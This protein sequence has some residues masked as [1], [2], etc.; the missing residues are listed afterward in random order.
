MGT[1]ICLC[2][3]RSYTK[4][5][6]H[7]MSIC[8]AE[9]V[10]VVSFE[11]LKS[12]LNQTWFIDIIWEPSYVH[13]KVVPRSKVICGQVVNLHHEQTATAGD[14][15]GPGT[16]KYFFFFFFYKSEGCA[17]WHIKSQG[18]QWQFLCKKG[19]LGDRSQNG[20]YCVWNCTK[21][22]QFRFCCCCYYLFCFFV[23]NFLCDL[24]FFFKIWWFRQ[25]FW[26]K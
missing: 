13:A 23:W 6:G 14:T 10:K 7:L 4:V 8:K 22:G 24:Q 18:N 17:Y 1:F 19:S 9:N 12:D 20:G 25:K 26:L 21:S 2:G 16:A 11:K 15:S 3:Q 5:K